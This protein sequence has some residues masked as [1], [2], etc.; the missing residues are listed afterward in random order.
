M[1]TNS[2]VGSTTTVTAGVMMRTARNAGLDNGDRFVIIG[3]CTL[4]LYCGLTCFAGYKR[5]TVRT[6]DRAIDLEAENS[7]RVLHVEQRIVRV[8]PQLINNVHLE[9]NRL[10]AEN[11]LRGQPPASFVIRRSKNPKERVISYRRGKTGFEHSVITFKDERWLEC[12][13]KGG[14][15]FDDLHQLLKH[16]KFERFRPQV[17]KKKSSR[18]KTNKI[19]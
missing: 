6:Q 8:Y 18:R 11:F 3:L 17:A 16:Y 1:E 12:S 5:W 4:L 14:E 15:W 9:F 19:H 13:I 10:Q 2:T 7:E